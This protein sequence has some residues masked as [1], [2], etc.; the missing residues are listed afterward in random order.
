MKMKDLEWNR[1]MIT[2]AQQLANVL[3]GR[4]SGS[5][6]IAE[7]PAHD[8]RKA[9]LSIKQ[10]DKVPIVVKCH[11]G[12][13]QESVLAELKLRQGVEFTSKENPLKKKQIAVYDYTDSNGNLL[14]QKVRYEPKDFRLRR[15][16]GNTGWIWNTKGLKEVL[17][18]LPRIKAAI[19][20]KEQIFIV[21]G[22]K[23]VE[24]LERLGLIATSNTHGASVDS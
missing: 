11:A 9:S 5:G 24:T 21:E 10:G 18:R 17:Y 13:T 14:Y 19:R 2:N 1:I 20:D 23:D 3:G 6:W 16:D 22:E 8:D 7:C 12:C 15:S 4:V